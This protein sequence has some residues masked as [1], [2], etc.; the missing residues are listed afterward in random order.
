VSKYLTLLAITL[1]AITACRDD[2]MATPGSGPPLNPIP[3]EVSQNADDWPLPNQ[4][5][6][7][8]RNAVSTITSDNVNNLEIAWTFD[9]PGAAA[10]GAAT[11][12][13]LILDGVVYFEDLE[14]NVF[15]LDLETGDVIW[16]RDYGEPNNGPNGV[17]AGWGRL[18]AVKGGTEIAALDLESGEELWTRKIGATEAEGIDIQP[19]VYQ[20]VLVSSVPGNNVENY[21]EPGTTGTIYGLEAETGNV[22]MQFDTVDSD[23]IW[24]NPDIN[25]GGGAW[26]PPAIDT[27]LRTMYWGIGN[28][29]PW[30]GTPEFPNGSSRP[31]PNLYTNSIVALRGQSVYW[32]TQI[33]PHDLFDRDLQ[34]AMFVTDAAVGGKNR[35]IV[36]GGGKSGIVT[37][38]DATNGEQLWET[39][40]GIHQNDDLKAVPDGAT[41]TVFPGIFGG[42]ETPMAYAD[43]IVYVPVVNL[44]ADY[45]ATEIV[46]GSYRLTEGTGELVAISI[47]NG[48]MLWQVDLPALNVGAATVVNDLIFT[49]TFDGIVYAFQRETGVE[50]WSMQ[51]PAGINAWP[52]VAGDTIVW[53][54]G[55]GQTPKLI[56]LRPESED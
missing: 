13:P 39:S 34:L 17:A 7:N 43:G 27:D 38:V 31:G 5:Y 20:W 30:P 21:Y 1:I 50:V 2:E 49:A 42:V 37:A 46:P 22:L 54:A 32:Y 26:Y 51:M 18:F 41:V 28:P 44:S 11:T 8:R 25:A 15:A 36:I 29:A 48:E 52:A 35:D 45:T 40:V 6:G 4:D 56:A 19:T 3:A 12:N 23:D 9:I 16:R 47:S 24:G 55:V 14:S 33:T 10:W 53:P